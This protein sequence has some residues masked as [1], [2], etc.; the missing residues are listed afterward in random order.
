MMHRW[1][2]LPLRVRLVSLGVVGLLIGFTIG[3]CTLV[4]ALHTSLQRS[5]DSLATKTAEDVAGLLVQDKLPDPIMTG[6][7]PSSAQVELICPPI[8]CGASAGAAR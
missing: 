8:I 6:R 4:W 7:D 5:V 3:G 2:T 1:H